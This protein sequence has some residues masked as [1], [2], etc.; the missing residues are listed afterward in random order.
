MTAVPRMSEAQWQDAVAEFAIVHGWRVAHFRPARTGSGGWATPVRYNGV[1]FPDLVMAH[2]VHQVVVFVEVKSDSGR[3]STDQAAWADT[4]ESVEEAA[5]GPA[6][7]AVR[8]FVW[9]PNNRDGVFAFLKDPHG[10]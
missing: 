4:L 5:N 7:A 3:L 8:Y 9:R 2:A 10:R 6:E 1:G